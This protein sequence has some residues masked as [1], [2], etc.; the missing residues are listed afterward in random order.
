M[1]APLSG[2]ELSSEQIAAVK[3][4]LVK[5]FNLDR[6]AMMV[7]R[8]L[9]IRLSDEVGVDR[10]FRQVVDTFVELAVEQFSVEQLVRAA[11]AELPGSPRIAAVVRQLRIDTDIPSPPAAD[12]PDR[13]EKLVRA[14][15]PSVNYADYLQRLTQLGRQLCRIEYGNAQ[16][17]GTGWLVA[18]DLVLTNYHVAKPVHENHVTWSNVSC[19]FDCFVDTAPDAK[20][21]GAE[22]GLAAEWLVDHSVF[23]DNDRVG[24]GPE[25]T[26][27][28]LDYALLRLAQP[29]GAE[30]TPEGTTRGFLAVSATPPT[31]MAGDIT[32]VVQHAGGRPLELAFGALTGYNNGGTRFRHDA[33]TEPGSSGSPVLTVL[34]QPFGLHHAGGPGEEFKYNQGIPLRRIVSVMTDKPGVPAFWS[35][36]VSA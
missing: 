21:P 11:H 20:P 7:R 33:N 4:A 28:A 19:R 3:D 18:P 34:L 36:V 1:P 26:D 13:L 16:A 23:T 14:R 6:F 10:G 32:L 8:R 15:A 31:V 27:A 9:G 22:V 12:D 29:I 35:P 5:S 17:G 24:T 2:D 25:P 30:S